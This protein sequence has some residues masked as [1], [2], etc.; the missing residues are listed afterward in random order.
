[1][2]KSAGRLN[3]VGEKPKTMWAILFSV[4]GVLIVVLIIAIA[5]VLISR[6][7]NNSQE[8]AEDSDP[9]YN[10]AVSTYF[11]DNEEIA[12]E[13]ANQGLDGNALMDLIKKKIDTTENEITK[14][15][16]EQDYYMTMFSTYGADEGKKDEILN[17]LIKVDE[18]LKT[19][20]SAENVA[21]IALAYYDFDTYDKYVEIIRE[22]NPDYK[23][24]YDMIEEM[25]Q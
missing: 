11:N 13:I 8:V 19:V 2:E 23:S 5:A 4:L 12:A 20:E 17:G 16:L 22:K 24:I 7:N 18:V 10:E 9:E 3:G 21:N 6:N 15:M 14:A 1:M 25:E